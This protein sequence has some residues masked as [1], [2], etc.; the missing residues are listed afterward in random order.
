MK[1]GKQL[2]R[3]KQL[4]QLKMHTKREE[5]IERARQIER[6]EHDDRHAQALLLGLYVLQHTMDPLVAAQ[7]KSTTTASVLSSVESASGGA[8]PVHMRLHM[9]RWCGA[10]LYPRI[11]SRILL[12]PLHLESTV[13]R[14]GWFRETTLLPRCRTRKNFQMGATASIQAISYFREGWPVL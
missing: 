8:S 9:R 10:T 13:W 7:A 4:Q 12:R 3:E 14:D 5:H 1:R 2:K 6:E 11:F